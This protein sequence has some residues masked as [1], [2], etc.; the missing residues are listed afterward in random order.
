MQ[1][2]KYDTSEFIRR[3]EWKAFFHA[4]PELEN[5][6]D[7]AADIHRDI[8]V[9]GFTH[10]AY[11]SPLLEEVKTKLFGWIA[12]HK[13]AK[14]K[15]NLSPLE[16]RGRRWILNNLKEEKIFIT[17]ADKGGFTLIMNFADVKAAI[18]NERKRKQIYSNRQV[19]G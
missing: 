14:P 4:N 7:P 2:L 12:N 8:R 5:N 13:V 3:L 10:P 11:N 18:E 19:F 1:E 16:L 15:A 17:K 6:I 9:S